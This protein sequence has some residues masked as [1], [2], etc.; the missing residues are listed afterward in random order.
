MMAL[1]PARSSQPL[2]YAHRGGAALRPENT[3]AAFDHGL[4]LGADG[5]ELDVHLSKDG[6]VVVHHDGTLER[7]TN[8]R[9]RVSA[10]TADELGAMDAGHWFDPQSAQRHREPDADGASFPFRGK[11]HGVPRLSKVL[12][13]YPGIPL[14][15]E[16]KVNEP[17]L[18]RRTIDEVRAA[19]AVDRVALGS[20]GWRTLRAARQYEPRI[21]TG[22]SREEVRLALYRSWVRWPLRAEAYREFQVPERSGPTRIVSRHFVKHAHRAGLPVK[23]WTVNDPQD[24]RRLL[25]WGVDALISDRPDLAVAA[26]KVQ[27][28]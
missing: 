18:A 25:E 23:V 5:L 20:F 4:A 10:F 22:A 27:T 8:G 13:R 26:V 21:S 17:E 3:I 7:T 6:I 12:S 16:L 15:I 1:A 24:M 9:G 19:G 11:G 28:F 2:V 14:I